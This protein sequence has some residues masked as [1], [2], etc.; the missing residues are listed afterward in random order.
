[1]LTEVH[2][3]GSLQQ[4][5]YGMLSQPMYRA[6]SS[7]RHGFRRLTDPLTVEFRELKDYLVKSCHRVHGL[8]VEL[9]DIYSVFIK[10]NLPNPYGDW[11][12]TK[13]TKLDYDPFGEERLLLW[14]GTPLDSLLGIVERF[15]EGT[16]LIGAAEVQLQSDLIR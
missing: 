4:N 3:Q 14:H 7:L 2:L 5:A 16:E 1:M 10:S 9:Q 15:T 8:Q 11:I 13:L 6:Y 12:E